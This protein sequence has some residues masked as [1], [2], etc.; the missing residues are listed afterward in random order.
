[1]EIYRCYKQ[2][3]LSPLENQL[4]KFTSACLVLN[5]REKC[6]NLV[7]G[8]TE[9]SGHL[10]LNKDSSVDH[11]ICLSLEKER[12][13]SSFEMP[14]LYFQIYLDLNRA[15]RAQETICCS[16]LLLFSFLLT[17]KNCQGGGS[18]PLWNWQ[19]FLDNLL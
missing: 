1:M 6:F 15:S 19:R 9:Q 3:P 11:S 12:S 2:R 10:Y 13:Y 18:D 4:L 16:K 17:P 14:S 8:S 5:E 7:L